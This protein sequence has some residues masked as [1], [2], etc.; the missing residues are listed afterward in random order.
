MNKL[1]IEKQA[2]AVAA[3]VEG[4]SIRSVERMTGIHRDTIMRL[5]VRTGQNCQA[6]MDS[7]MHNLKCENVQVDEIWCYVGKKQRHVKI[8]DNLNEVGDQWVWWPS[9]PIASSYLPSW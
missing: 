7:S 8:R 1:S 3:L 6:L 4:A 9:T 2:M 5:M